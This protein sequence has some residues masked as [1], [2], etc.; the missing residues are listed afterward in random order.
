VSASYWGMSGSK[1]EGGAWGGEA[2]PFGLGCAEGGVGRVGCAGR[3]AG[4]VVT[5]V[6]GT[7][8]R[9]GAGMLGGGAADTLCD[10]SRREALM[11]ASLLSIAEPVGRVA[12]MD[13]IVP[14][15][16]VMVSS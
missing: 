8:A 3:G 15:W 13:W 16:V 14:N 4:R 2:R 6:G 11:G 9:G 5:L 1:E 10:R 7:G 12:T